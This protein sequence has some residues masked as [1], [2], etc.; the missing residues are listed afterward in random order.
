MRHMAIN[1]K[2]HRKFD[3]L[4]N[5][6]RIKCIFDKVKEYFSSHPSVVRFV[7]SVVSGNGFTDVIGNSFV[8]IYN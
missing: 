6:I 5:Q 4:R 8:R 3:V 1:K 7:N 2:Y